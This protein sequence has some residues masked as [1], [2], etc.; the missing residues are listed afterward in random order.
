MR[1]RTFFDPTLF[2]K[3]LA[4]FWPLWGVYFLVWAVP[5]PLLM[6]YNFLGGGY[7]AGQGDLSYQIDRHVLSCSTQAAVIILFIFAVFAAMAVFSYLYAQKSA[8][9]YHSLPLDRTALF[10]TGYLSGLGFLLLPHLAVFLLTLLVEALAGHVGFAALLVWLGSVSACAF[11]FYSFAVFCAVFIGQL[12]ALPIFYGILSFLIPGIE[13]L[14]R[15]ALDEF[16]YGFPGNSYDLAFTAFS[17]AIQLME[18]LSYRFDWEDDVLTG[19]WHFAGWQWLLVYAAVAAALTAL[20]FWVYRRRRVES[21][22][23]LVSVRAVRPVFKYGMALCAA[24][25]LGRWLY[26]IFSFSATIWLLLAFMWL[27]GFLGYFAAE[28]LLKKSFRVFRRGIRG[29]LVFALVLAVSMTAMEYDIFGYEKRVPDAQDVSAV[30][31][32]EGYYRYGLGSAPALTSEDDIAAVVSLHRSLTEGKADIE[33]Q[34]SSARVSPVAAE[35]VSPYDSTVL[36]FPVYSTA[37]VSVR[38]RLESGGE[39]TRTYSIPVTRALLED[40]ESPAA[41]FEALLR[42]PAL[43]RADLYDGDPSAFIF[44]GGSLQLY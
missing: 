24:L 34:L 27:G 11:F 13:W 38:Y 15:L 1:S 25:T 23:D 3:N 9:F 31:V 7:Y 16:V 40:P 26:E 2:R 20:A 32:N 39:M 17:P 8:V 28:M 42:T 35:A 6:A 22:G 4:R 37:Q 30:Y 5:L 36:Y 29:Y 41:Q 10:F 14:V 19:V 33:A 43:L 21:A 18:D 12:L 44:R